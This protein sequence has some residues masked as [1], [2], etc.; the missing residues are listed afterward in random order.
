[1]TLPLTVKDVTMWWAETG[2][3]PR[4]L[5]SGQEPANRDMNEFCDFEQ[6]N[7]GKGG[8]EKKGELVHNHFI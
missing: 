1:M 5:V 6:E 8:K 4:E 3:G 2:T 7:R